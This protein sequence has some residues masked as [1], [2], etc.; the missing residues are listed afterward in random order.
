[1]APERLGSG[2][3]GLGASVGPVELV[4]VRHGLP[5]RVD[6]AEGGGPA[7]PGL[8][9]AGVEQA[10][11]VAG[12]LGGERIDALVT[13][14]ARRARETALPIARALGLEPTVVDGVA[15]FDAAAT[16]YVPVEELRAAGDERWEL[17]KAGD[18]YAL[19]VDPVAFRARVV[20][21]LAR[22]AADRPGGR[23][24]VVTHSGTINAAAGA[25]L[26][27]AK[28]IWLAPAYC[29]LTRLA[30]ARDGRRGVLSLNEA[31][32]VRDLL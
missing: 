4:L 1:M 2:W 7:D 20:A 13:S 16:S 8:A 11:R 29:S 24:V 3:A 22:V 15:E 23:V 9:P 5:F 25:I 12:C 32:H 21:A 19:D 10:A 17:L 30:Y 27:Q 31:G 18:L 26:G 28:A 6:A 14:P